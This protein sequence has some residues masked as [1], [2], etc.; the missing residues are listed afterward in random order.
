MF[1]GL[2]FKDWKFND[3][4][5]RYNYLEPQNIL[6]DYRDITDI[7]GPYKQ[8]E[9]IDFFNFIAHVF[10]EESLNSYLNPANILGINLITPFANMKMGCEIDLVRVRNGENKYLNRE[11]FAMRYPGLKPNKK[12]PMPRAV[13]V[14]LKEWQ[15]PIRPEFKPFDINE[16]KPDQKWLVY[17][18][19]QFL[20]M[21]DKGELYD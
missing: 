10:A 4:I 8:G 17:I 14:W 18:L 15:G 2:L 1:D 13:G 6:K 21:L 9:N 7:Y 3:F 16:L 19:E 11:L 12:L 5:H 20:N